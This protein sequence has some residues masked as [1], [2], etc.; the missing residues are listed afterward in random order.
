MTAQPSTATSGGWEQQGWD[1]AQDTTAGEKGVPSHPAL[2]STT[3]IAAPSSHRPPPIPVRPHRPFP[4]PQPDLTQ[5]E[6]IFPI[7]LVGR[8]I[9]FWKNKVSRGSKS[10]FGVPVFHVS[11]LPY[12]HIYQR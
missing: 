6:I 8:K 5:Q 9:H 4:R 10:L 7:Q 11:L 2:P 3:G 1:V 12:S